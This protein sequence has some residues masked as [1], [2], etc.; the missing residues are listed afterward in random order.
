[1][2]INKISF[3]HFTAFKQL[4]IHCSEGINIF[5]GQNGM[6]KTHILKAAYAACDIS[7]SGVTFAKKLV[8][9]FMPSANQLNRLV[10]RQPGR[11][12]AGLEISRADFTL[13][14]TFSSLSKTPEAPSVNVK[15]LEKWIA[16][17]V[18]SVY[19]YP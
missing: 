1:M 18:K 7:K 9:V 8:N 11:G 3:D 4:E 10:Y 5:I 15:G 14:L 12:K 2:S 6:G 16:N 13:Q 19:C 17:P